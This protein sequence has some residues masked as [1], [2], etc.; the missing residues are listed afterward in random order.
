MIAKQGKTGPSR[1]CALYNIYIWYIYIT[2]CRLFAAI[3]FNTYSNIYLVNIKTLQVR[4]VENIL[5][6]RYKQRWATV[7]VFVYS[8][9]FY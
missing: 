7:V 8:I 5:C 6:Y 4:F 3:L 1:V 9:P 2:E